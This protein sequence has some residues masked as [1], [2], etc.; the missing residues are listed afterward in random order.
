MSDS[1]RILAR[2]SYLSTQMGL[3]KEWSAEDTVA[4]SQLEGTAATLLRLARAPD[5][6]PQLRR[7]RRFPATLTVVLARLT[8]RSYGFAFAE[9]VVLSF[10]LLSMGWKVLS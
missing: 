5:D 7:L 1:Y 3:V 10:R 9:E 4:F 6:D 8:G 2:N